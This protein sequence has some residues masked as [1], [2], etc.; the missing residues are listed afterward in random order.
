MEYN[1]F[2]LTWNSKYAYPR[3]FK[4][5][6]IC[7]SLFSAKYLILQYWILII[8]PSPNTQ[9]ILYKM[10]P[11]EQRSQGSDCPEYWLLL[12]R[13]A[14]TFTRLSAASTRLPSTRCSSSGSL[15]LEE[16]GIWR[17]VFFKNTGA[18]RGYFTERENPWVSGRS[19]QHKI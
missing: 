8:I 7:F 18:K 19:N 5:D 15:R 4:G 9:I 13:W 3:H 1:P 17:R 12:M 11:Y 6:L 10:N 2:P 16:S 14:D